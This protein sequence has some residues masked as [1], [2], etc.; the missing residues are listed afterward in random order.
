MSRNTSV[1][2]GMTA[3]QTECQLCC[4]SIGRLNRNICISQL[5]LE[6]IHSTSHIEA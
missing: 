1:I 2:F 3:K 4:I 5:V 6:I